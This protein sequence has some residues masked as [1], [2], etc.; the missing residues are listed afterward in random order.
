MIQLKVKMNMKVIII[1]MIKLLIVII[2]VEMYYLLLKTSI[3]RFASH[4]DKCF[5]NNGRQAT[6]EPVYLD[7]NS[8]I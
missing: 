4:L 6:H 3:S 2:V 5:N 1:V 7:D 8:I